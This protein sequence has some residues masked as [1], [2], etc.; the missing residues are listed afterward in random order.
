ME[1]IAENAFKDI[2]RYNKVIFEPAPEGTEKVY[3]LSIDNNA[4][5][6]AGIT[7]IE[8]PSRIKM[9][10]TAVFKGC[11]QLVSVKFAK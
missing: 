1:V 4:F 6:N 3:E 9:L 2:K 8:L 7:E 11:K 5:Q 10:G